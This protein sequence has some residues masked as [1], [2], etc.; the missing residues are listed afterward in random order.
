MR[1]AGECSLIHPALK[2]N[3]KLRFFFLLALAGGRVF[4]WFNNQ[5]AGSL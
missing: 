1:V 4:T 2:Q 5:S 3:D